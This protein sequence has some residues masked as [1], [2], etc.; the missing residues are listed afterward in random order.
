MLEYVEGETLADRL[1]Q[2]ALT[3][4]DGLEVCQQI[5]EALGAAHEAGIVHRDLKPANVM[6]RPDGTVKRNNFV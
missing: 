4:E 6:L 3:I 5:A 1:H 2:G